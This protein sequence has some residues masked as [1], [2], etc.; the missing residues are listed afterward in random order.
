[1]ARRGSALLPCLAVAAAFC[2]AWCLVAQEPAQKV[3]VPPQVRGGAAAGLAAAI[4]AASAAAP[5]PAEAVSA[6]FDI[7]GFGSSGF[8]DPYSANDADAISPYSQFSN[9][10]VGE[11]ALCDKTNK[12]RV[13]KKKVA[14]KNSFSRI[15]K[16]PQF[17]SNRQGE[18]IKST[19]TLQTY[20]MRSNMEFLSGSR[21][22]AA[23]EKAR[24]FFQD[25]AD[26]GVGAR[27]KRWP[28]AAESYDKAQN[29]LSQW[30]LMVKF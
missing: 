3:F 14:L 26:V 30:N 15:E 8:S 29:V 23:F 20:V 1:M 27:D 24:A 22:S 7:F 28:L 4:V 25:V 18:E 2:A 6:K 12:D 11:K 19:L 21:D 16:I 10:A 9:P 5:L 17:I 13:E